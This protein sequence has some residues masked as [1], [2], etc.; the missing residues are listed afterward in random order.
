M[1]TQSAVLSGVAMTFLV[2]SLAIFLMIAIRS[3]HLDRFSYREFKLG[4]S[5]TPDPVA[6]AI[7]ELPKMRALFYEF[8]ACWEDR[9][10]PCNPDPIIARKQS[11]VKAGWPALFDQL[12][13]KK[14]WGGDPTATK[15]RE[16]FFSELD[17]RDQETLRNIC[18]PILVFL[19]QAWGTGVQSFR[20]Y[21]FRGFD[22]RPP[23]KPLATA[24]PGLARGSTTFLYL[25]KIPPSGGFFI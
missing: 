16:I 6:E 4:I 20:N 22:C 12:I 14:D 8:D 11:I 25:R 19:N 23:H 10:R 13:T 21:F 5:R 24:P 9:S 3:S 17:R 15:S 2:I 7:M 18:R 1:R